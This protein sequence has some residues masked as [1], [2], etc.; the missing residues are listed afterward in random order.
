MDDDEGRFAHDWERLV[1]HAESEGSELVLLP[2]M[3]FHSWFAASPKFSPSVWSEV[4]EAH[5]KWMKR[6]VELAPATVIGSRTVNRGGRRLNDGFMW[7]EQKGARSVHAKRYLPDEEGYYEA[8]W[9]HRG[10]GRFSLFDA[11][12][13]R[14]GM[15]ICSDLWSMAN[16]RRYGKN[17][18]HLIAIPHAAPKAS[19]ERWLAGG[20]VVA[21]ISGAFC[22]ASNRTGEGV[23]VQFGGS[24]WVIGP[25]AKVLGLTSRENPF[26]TVEIDLRDAEEA[27]KT[28][29]RD[30]LQPD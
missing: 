19:M 24:G 8:S 28:Y 2:E 5:E 27:K 30:V 1:R 10:D 20:K 11:S 23:G 12:G 13:C 29:P 21:L 25:D 16:A 4:V 18:A 3:P 26:V 14:T 15:M 9:Y 7:T 6:L 22:I 17:G